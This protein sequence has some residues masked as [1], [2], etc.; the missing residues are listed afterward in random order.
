VSFVLAICVPIILGWIIVGFRIWMLH[1]NEQ[2]SRFVGTIDLVST[3][4][5]WWIV[6][7]CLSYSLTVIAVGYNGYCPSLAESNYLKDLNCGYSNEHQMPEDL[8]MV[9]LVMPI[10]LYTIIKGAKRSFLLLSFGIN[11]FSILFTIFAFDLTLSL[12]SY[13][14]FSPIVLLFMYEKQR[15]NIA[16][17]L[18][19]QNQETLIVE[20]ERL[21]AE[22]RA[23]EL[24]HLIGNVAHD[25]KTVRMTSSLRCYFSIIV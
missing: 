18:L 5:S 7:T 15:Q 12:G 22:T 10:I 9:S 19:T 20:N 6:G 21:E 25:L 3:M 4:E 24:K 13:I 1:G 8:M 17:F 23:N 11:F 16:V 2:S 14:V